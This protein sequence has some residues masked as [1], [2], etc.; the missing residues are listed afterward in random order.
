MPFIEYVPIR[1]QAATLLILEKANKIID[2]WRAK[3]FTLTLRQIYYRM[4]ALD[5]IPDSWIDEVYNKRH[6]L[7]ARTKNTIRNYKRLGD[8]LVAGRLGGKVDWDAMEDRTRNLRGLQHWGSPAEGLAWLSGQY[9]IEKWKDQPTR[10]EIWIEKDALLGIFEHI[11]TQPDIDIPFFSCRGYNSESEMWNAAQRILFFQKEHNQKTVVLQFSDH[12]P[13]GL[14][15]T[16]DIQDRLDLFGCN[17]EIRRMALNISHVKQFGLPPNPAKET[18]IR[19]EGYAAKFGNESWELDALEPDFL[20][21]EVRKEIEG[22]RDAAQWA[23][24]M[25]RQGT[26]QHN[27]RQAR[28]A[29]PGFGVARKRIHLENVDI[30]ALELADALLDK[31]HKAGEPKGYFNM[32]LQFIF[33]K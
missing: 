28:T 26:E 9:R 27:I 21:Q 13:S 12:D 20:L 18:D 31:W 3:G 2:D 30:V 15:M 4:I 23:E 24:A 7:P 32:G 14:D 25:A 19:F 16:R 29:V 33:D 11:C 1:S 5:W 17:V 6:G 10:V 22:I 8:I